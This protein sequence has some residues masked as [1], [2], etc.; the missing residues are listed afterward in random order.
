V[1][2]GNASV[3]KAMRRAVMKDVTLLCRWKARPPRGGVGGRAGL[4]PR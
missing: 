1:A 3:L 4:V 2:S